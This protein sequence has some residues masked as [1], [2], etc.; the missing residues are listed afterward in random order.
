MFQ[1]ILKSFPKVRGDWKNF[2]PKFSF[3]FGQ[4]WKN[5]KSE[6][7]KF[8]SQS[9]KK[10]EKNWKKSNF[11]G[12]FLCVFFRFVL[13]FHWFFLRFSIF[14]FFEI[15]CCCFFEKI[16]L[17]FFQMDV[18]RSILGRF[19]FFLVFQK[20]LTLLFRLS[21]FLTHFEG[22]DFFIKKFR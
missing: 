1:S 8:W 6:I 12:S 22:V 16:F 21:T 7:L 13:I 3:F 10:V 17:V 18:S 2:D 19:Q 15:C 4:K 9:W 20:A 11:F 14:R 5:R